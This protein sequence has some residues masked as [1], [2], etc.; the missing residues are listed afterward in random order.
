MKNSPAPESK[1]HDGTPKAPVF[2]PP[3][4]KIEHPS[5]EEA[6]IG[7]GKEFEVAQPEEVPA[8]PHEHGVNDPSARDSISA[9]SEPGFS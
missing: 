5:K 8:Q 6:V 2:T 1:D 4:P 9:S 3:I 7:D